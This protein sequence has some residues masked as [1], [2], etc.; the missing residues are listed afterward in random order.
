LQQSVFYVVLTKR[1]TMNPEETIE[2]NKRCAEF[3]GGE[4]Q[5]LFMP[6]A[7][8][9]DD[10]WFDVNKHPELQN[11]DGSSMWKLHELKFHSDW[12]WI[13]EV[14]EAIQKIVIKNNE[15][16]CIE[17]YEGLPNEPKTIVSVNNIIT[18]DKNPKKAVVS[19]INKFLIRYSKY[20]KK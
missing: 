10:M 4:S 1:N 16:F 14:V 7:P 2:F 13:M 8:E 12:N 20:N 17:F 6:Y 9:K 15:E 5:P 18:K 19:T 11:P 3:L